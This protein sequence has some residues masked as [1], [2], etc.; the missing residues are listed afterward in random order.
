MKNTAIKIMSAV[1]LTV[2]F[3]AASA[4]AQNA[5]RYTAYIPFDFNIGKVSFAAGEYK[6]SHLNPAQ[7]MGSVL[8][9]SADG[10]VGKLTMAGA[11]S[12]AVGT[13]SELIFNRYDGQYFLAEIITPAISVAFRPTTGERELARRIGSGREAISFSG[14]R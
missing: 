5:K 8:I 7:E 11:A 13:R 4:S 1:L 6:I 10:K 2:A 12:Q 3:A 9:Q 14:T